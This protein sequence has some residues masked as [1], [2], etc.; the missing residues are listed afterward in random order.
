MHHAASRLV[1]ALQDA[2]LTRSAAALRDVMCALHAI[3]TA[4][5][6]GHATYRVR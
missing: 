1:I 6:N 5:T 2:S 3:T 4:C